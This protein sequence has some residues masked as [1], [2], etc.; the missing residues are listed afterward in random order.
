MCRRQIAGRRKTTSRAG[1]GNLADPS[2]LQKKC[3]IVGSIAR[4]DH[5]Y[6]YLSIGSDY[7]SDLAVRGRARHNHQT[8]LER[9]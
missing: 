1:N 8:L 3:V 2:D 9:T 7:R 4:F 6:W 5:Q